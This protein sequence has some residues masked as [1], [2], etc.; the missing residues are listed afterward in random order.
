[1]GSFQLILFQKYR[2]TFGYLYRALKKLVRYASYH[3]I[4]TGSL[5]EG[6]RIHSG[7]TIKGNVSQIAL[8]RNY[9]N[10]WQVV[11][12]NV[13][14]VFISLY[15]FVSGVQS[16]DFV[17]DTLFFTHVEPMLN[18]VE[19]S[20]SFADKNMYGLL[21]NTKVQVPVN[22]RKMHG[23]YLDNHYDQVTDVDGTLEKLAGTYG[24][25]VV[26]FA[27]GSQGG[28]N[29]AVITSRD[30]K[31]FKN[32]ETIE[33]KWLDAHYEDN[34][35]LQAFVLQHPF[36]EAFNETSLNTLRV[37]TYRSVRDE[38]LHV[39]H[40]VLRVGQK[41][42]LVDNISAGGIALG[43]DRLGRLNGN[44]CGLDGPVDQKDININENMKRGIHL[45]QYK[46]V[47]DAA[48]EIAQKQFYTRL[49]GFDFC[50][51]TEENVRLIELN[52]Y[53]VGVDILQLCNGPL[54]REF[55]DEVIEFCVSQ[56]RKLRYVIR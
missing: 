35:L 44:V 51:D 10:K 50:V 1:M 29:I 2:Q 19:Y 49:I 42:A 7:I 45:F 20:R 47:V 48:L 26:K 30:G 3:Q 46:K 18:N 17:P 34:F 39:L 23:A 4:H 8:R 28:K 12:R 55:T 36:Y 32:E 6:K 27:M 37:Y 43:V 53:D 38:S 16:P 52:N 31:W 5:L 54:F 56:K 22:I 25:M 21:I 9:L 41:G 24:K 15:P 13:P 11:S 40:S 14:G 33:R